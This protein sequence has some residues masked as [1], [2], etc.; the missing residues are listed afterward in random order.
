V[1]FT[2]RNIDSLLNA[3]TLARETHQ[4]QWQSKDA[5]LQHIEIPGEKEKPA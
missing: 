4:Q 3:L 2:F 5:R 1:H